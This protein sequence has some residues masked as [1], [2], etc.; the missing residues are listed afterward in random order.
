MFFV[1]NK[2]RYFR[3]QVIMTVAVS[4]VVYLAAKAGL[5]GASNHSSPARSLAVLMFTIGPILAACV[6]VYF[7]RGALRLSSVI[8]FAILLYGVVLI[9]PFVIVSNEAGA[10][11]DDQETMYFVALNFVGFL[12]FGGATAWLGKLVGILTLA[13]FSF[14]AYAGSSE[15]LVL[16][17][18]LALLNVTSPIAQWT[19]AIVITVSSFLADR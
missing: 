15:W 12:I 7:Q 9:W 4:M 11:F 6:L 16:T 14:S 19:I 8:G 18:V 1:Q 3:V 5:I 13:A 17:P 2:H 10:S